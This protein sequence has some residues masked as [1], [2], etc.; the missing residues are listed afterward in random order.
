MLVGAISLTHVSAKMSGP[1]VTA[2]TTGSQEQRQ[3]SLTKTA[4]RLQRRIERRFQKSPG[5]PALRNAVSVRRAMFARNVTIAMQDDATGEEIS[6]WSVSLGRY[7]D[8]MAFDFQGEAR[9]YLDEQVIAASI[10][11]TPP[12]G[13]TVPSFATASTTIGDGKVQRTTVEGS[14][15]DGQ[16][17]DTEELVGTI[18]KAFQHGQ[19]LAVFPVQ[20]INGA[21][22][23]DDGSSTVVLHE[24]GVGRSEFHSSPWGRKQNV[25]KAMN[26]KA[27]GV[28]IPQGSTFSFNATLGGAI[29]HGNGWYDSLIIVNGKD[30]EPAPG[31]GICQ[32]ATT[33]FRAAV[34]AGLPITTRKSHSLYVHYYKEFG[35]G[36]DATV[37]PGRQDMQF[38]ND[39]PGPMILVGMTDDADNAYSTLYGVEDDRA[40]TM[41]GPYFGY[42][43]TEP[44]M[45]RTLRNG[46]VAW[47]QHVQNAD[48]TTRD[49]LLV[50]QYTGLPKSVALEY[51][52]VMHGAG[53]LVADAR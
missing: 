5:L 21:I 42:T 30:L 7:P 6:T 36:L 44:V 50:A 12:D 4:E 17:Y 9:F 39:T 53:D 33:V 29:T 35:M 37:F 38:T 25:R 43:H 26:E 8:W 52:P 48:G 10:A 22:L 3:D 13:L 34:A 47:I 15:S 16:T 18:V 23:Y 14:V 41:E 24:L 49:Q 1:Q 46:E 27:N 28:V 51:E 2:K 11:A 20:N 40:V 45:G 32:A 31:G 19:D